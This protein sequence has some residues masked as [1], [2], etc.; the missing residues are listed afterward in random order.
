M[1]KIYGEKEIDRSCNSYLL[2]LVSL[3]LQLLS[4]AMR[5]CSQTRI[6]VHQMLPTEH[7]STTWSQELLSGD[8]TGEGDQAR[9][10]QGDTVLSDRK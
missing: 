7:H 8:S 3:S 1:G 6:S 2:L 10:L 5:T 9:R 4:Q